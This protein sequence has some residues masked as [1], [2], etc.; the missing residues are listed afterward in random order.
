[1]Q[2]HLARKNFAATQNVDD[3]RI[4]LGYIQVRVLVL[5]FTTAAI[6]GVL[7]K[8]DLIRLH[9]IP[10]KRGAQIIAQLV[11]ASDRTRIVKSSAASPWE[12]F[13]RPDHA[14]RLSI[15]YSVPRKHK[16]RPK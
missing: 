14:Q 8:L 11:I 10:P 3:K 4:G 6:R 9:V 15:H 5:G 13:L 7:R 12:V 16:R 1:M 2:Q